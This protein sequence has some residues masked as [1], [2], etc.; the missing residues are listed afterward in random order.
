MRENGGH[1]GSSIGEVVV[2]LFVYFK[3]KMCGGTIEYDQFNIYVLI[4]AMFF[5]L[6]KY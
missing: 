6:I 4:K 3:K 5:L 1:G 2:P